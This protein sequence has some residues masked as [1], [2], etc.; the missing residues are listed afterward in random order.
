M[1]QNYK[2]VLCK[3]VKITYY[4]GHKTNNFMQKKENIFK[5]LFIDL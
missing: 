4:L 2:Q 3:N 1:L 5:N